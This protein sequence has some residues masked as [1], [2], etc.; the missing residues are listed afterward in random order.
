MLEEGHVEAVPVP[1]LLNAVEEVL[2]DSVD[3]L[4]VT[5]AAAV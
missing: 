2:A 3:I 1:E 5:V 4:W